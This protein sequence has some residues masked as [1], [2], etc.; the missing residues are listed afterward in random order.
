VLGFPY[1]STFGPS[2]WLKEM[3]ARKRVQKRKEEKVVEK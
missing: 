3:L 2:F 1:D